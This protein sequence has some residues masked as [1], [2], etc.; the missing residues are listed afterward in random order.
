[1]H[2]KLNYASFAL[3][4]QNPFL[5]Q[6]DVWRHQPDTL[7]LNTHEI[8]W[9]LFHQYHFSI[10]L[11][12]HDFK[13]KVKFYSN[14]QVNMSSS[15]LLYLFSLHFWRFTVP[16]AVCLASADWWENNHSWLEF[17][18]GAMLTHWGRN[19]MAAIFQTTFSNAFY[20]MKMYEFL[21]RFHWSL[22]QR[23]KLTIFQ[24]WFI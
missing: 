10:I 19:K 16:D 22:F 17:L 13:D 15:F 9:Y 8:D 18:A 12:C 14:Q 21:L 2:Q 3:I 5:F 11:V 20:W 7:T 6:A 24:P 4:H 23:V 1:M